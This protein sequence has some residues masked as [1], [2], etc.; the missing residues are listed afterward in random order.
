MDIQVVSNFF[1]ITSSH[2]VSML[3]YL[4]VLLEQLL[5][6]G[7]SHQCAHIFNCNRNSRDSNFCTDL[8]CMIELI[9][10]GY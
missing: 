1:A 6:V 3:E 8:E 2:I 4:P 10:P 5:E 9:S 7:L